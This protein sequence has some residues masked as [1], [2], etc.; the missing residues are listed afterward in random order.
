M[1]VYVGIYNYIYKKI[2]FM[3]KLITLCLIIIPLSLV[4]QNKKIEKISFEVSGNCEMCKNRIEKAALSVKGVK[5]ATWDIPS[6][7]ISVIFDANKIPLEK[8]QGAIA[9]AG[10]DTPLSKASDETYNELPLC[11]LYERKIQ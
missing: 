1:Q 7:L 4:A 9:S 10:H 6:N 5:T 8:V 11:C 3:K 2:R